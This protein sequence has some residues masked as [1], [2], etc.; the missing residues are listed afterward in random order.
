MLHFGVHKRPEKPSN[1]P[2]TGPINRCPMGSDPGASVLE[3][4]QQS[5]WSHTFDPHMDTKDNQSVHKWAGPSIEH[6]QIGQTLTPRWIR[7]SHAQSHP[8]PFGRPHDR[9]SMRAGRRRD[10]GGPVRCWCASRVEVARRAAAASTAGR[11]ANARCPSSFVGATVERT[12]WPNQTSV[13]SI[14]PGSNGAFL[15]MGR[16]QLDQASAFKGHG[17]ANPVLSI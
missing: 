8:A 16:A 1:R 13:A 10:N 12:G 9:R 14:E 5:A 2:T 3:G 17:I 6:A 11:K 4:N 15:P 7:A